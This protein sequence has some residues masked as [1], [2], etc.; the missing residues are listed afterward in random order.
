MRPE[1]ENDNGGLPTGG[2]QF[3]WEERCELNRVPI[4]TGGISAAKSAVSY[5]A[6]VEMYLRSFFDF[7]RSNSQANKFTDRSVSRLKNKHEKKSFIEGSR[8]PA[9]VTLQFRVDI[10]GKGTFQFWKHFAAPKRA[11]CRSVQ[12]QVPGTSECNRA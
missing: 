2:F 7:P 8:A 12:L 5:R 11:L 6:G 9:T 3:Q 10:R 4:G 1:H